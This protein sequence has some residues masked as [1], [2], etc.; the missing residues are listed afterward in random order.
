[1]EV[2]H[3]KIKSNDVVEK[4]KKSNIVEKKQLEQR[5][6]DLADKIEDCKRRREYT[7]AMEYYWELDDLIHG[8]VR[9]RIE[10]L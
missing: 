4:I 10:K 3:T 6:K 7:Q 5:K 9:K 2:Y 8:R 1:M